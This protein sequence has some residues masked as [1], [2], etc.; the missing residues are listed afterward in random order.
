[1]QSPPMLRRD[2]SMAA[3]TTL[4]VGGPAR[5]YAQAAN[6][7]ELVQLTQWA[8]H[9]DLA[10]LILGGGSNLLVAD[11]GY[12]GL[13]LS[14]VDDHISI[15]H[16]GNQAL[17]RVGAG[18]TWDKLVA[19]AVNNDLAGI[20]CLSGIPGSVGAAPIQNIGAYGQE[21]AEVL[22]CVHVLDIHSGT[23]RSIPP[24]ECGFSYRHSHFK[25]EWKGRFIVTGVDLSLRMGPPAMPRY[26]A[27]RLHLAETHGPGVPTVEQIRRAVL[28]IRRQK[29]MVL[30]PQDPNTRSAG[31]FFTNPVVPDALADSVAAK[32]A[33]EGPTRMP[34]W[35]ATAKHSKL[36]AAWLIE[37]SGFSKG[38]ADG[39]VGLSTKHC[40][41]LINR[42]GARAI[43][44]A[45]LAARIRLAV[46][47]HYAVRLTPEPVFVGFHLP[48]N[49]L[50][51][52]LAQEQQP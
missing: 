4:A 37:H 32:A 48:T 41:A 8:E 45:R 26:P 30:D 39:R 35:P 5:W 21:I 47:E 14:H 25:G 2:Q 7:A 31:S 12:E 40:L 15:E 27:L 46:F 42:G 20:E 18:C 6:S 51:D 23:Q 1:M 13:V 38:F 11:S 29:S 17:L 10:L 52:R 24:A 43:D 16:L 28:A 34:R 9:M 22:T 3:R 49:D 19:Y 50:L 36:S 33:T 44:I